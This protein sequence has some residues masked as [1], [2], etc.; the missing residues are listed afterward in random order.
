[1][2][3]FELKHYFTCRPAEPHTMPGKTSYQ[4]AWNQDSAFK[5]W[6]L[7]VN[8]NPFVAKCKFCP[9]KRINISSMGRRALTSHAPGQKHKDAVLHAARVET[10]GAYISR[11]Q[12]VAAR[13]PT[14]QVSKDEQ[15]KA[16]I[17][18][19]IK[20]VDSNYS[21]NSNA[22]IVELFGRIFTD[23]TIAKT[24]TIGPTKTMYIS[25]FGVAPYFRQLIIDRV[26]GEPY[27]LMFDETLNHELQKKQSDYLVR[28]WNGPMI[29]SFYLTS[30]FLGHSACSNMLSS[31][32]CM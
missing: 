4:T 21:F 20:C 3:N 12:T 17:L 26:R 16:E 19:A 18:W 10:M 13:P 22:G 25:C 31:M 27:V 7:P 11:P 8:G 29:Q 6:V 30:D 5:D 15:L 9:A 2:I 1:M 24:M 28:F 23:S 32:S 14:V